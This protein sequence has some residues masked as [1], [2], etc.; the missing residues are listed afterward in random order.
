[1]ASLLRTLSGFVRE[2]RLDWAKSN[3]SRLKFEPSAPQRLFQ[4]ASASPAKWVGWTF[5]LFLL[6]TCLSALAP[7]P[8]PGL[9]DF[10][11]SDDKYT[12]VTAFL[13]LWAVQGA[14]VAVVYPI[15]V[16]FVTVLIQR[17]AASKASL[18]A[19]F[20]SSSAKLTGISSLALVLIMGVQFTTIDT[21]KPLLGFA[22]V[23]ADGVWFVA[24][25]LLSIHFL[26]A[27]FKFASPE[28]RIRA[29]NHYI[30]TR[31]WPEEW[32]YHISRL[33]AM[34]PIRRKLLNIPSGMEDLE[35]PNPAFSA[36]PGQLGTHAALKL[37]FRGA[38]KI[39]DVRYRVLEVAFNRWAKHAVHRTPQNTPG[40]KA[41][42]SRK[43]PIL[44]MGALVFNEFSHQDAL[45]KTNTPVSSSMLVRA[46]L[47]GSLKLSSAHKPRVTVLDALDESRLDAASAIGQDSVAD[48]ERRLEEFIEF[49]DQLIE[50]SNYVKDGKS[51]NWSLLQSSDEL[52][53]GRTLGRLW[54][55]S[56]LD[57]HSVALS[58]IERRPDFA[59]RTVRVPS[60]FF[61]RQRDYL[62]D[63]LK[64]RYLSL[65]FWHVRQLLDWGA[66]RLA[67]VADGSG[68]RLLGEPLRRRYERLIK[69][70][71][72]AW[73]SLKNWRLG[74]DLSEDLDWQQ[75]QSAAQLLEAHLRQ[76]AAFV[77]VCLRA[78]DRAGTYWFG[79]SFL[80]WR[81][82][83]ERYGAREGVAFLDKFKV[84]Y[85]DLS[86]NIGDFRRKFPLDAYEKESGATLRAAWQLAL[87]NFWKDVGLLLVASIATN[88]GA[89]DSHMKLSA[90]F[91]QSALLG[92]DSDGASARSERLFSGTDQ[93]IAA[94]IRV[95]ALG[96]E[97]PE[98]YSERLEGI[99]ESFSLS[100]VSEGI[101]GRIYSSVGT[102]LDRLDDGYLF[103]LAGLAS[104]GW[105][106]SGRFDDA[107][108]GWVEKDQIRQTLAYR[109]RRLRDRAAATIELQWMKPI[110]SESFQRS[111]DDF[112]KSLAS[113]VTALDDFIH[114]IERAREEDVRNLEPHP[115]E[116][117]RLEAYSS[118]ALQA[119]FREAPLCFFEAVSVEEQAFG[120][121][122]T[123]SVRIAGW[124]KGSLT[125]PRLA[126]P[127]SNEDDYI[128]D[129]VRQVASSLVIRAIVDASG[130]RLVGSATREEFISEVVQFGRDA[131]AVG[132]RPVLLVASRA[133]PPWLIDLA[134]G[135]SEDEKA[136]VFKRVGSA[137]NAPSYSG[138]IGETEV[139]VAPVPQ[140]EA[141]LCVA[142]MFHTL[143]VSARVLASA[144]AE[145]DAHRCTLGLSWGQLSELRQRQVVRLQY[146]RARSKRKRNGS[147]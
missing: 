68:G 31:A 3:P 60:R 136:P 8:Y 40:E 2:Q 86:L 29:R 109:F 61:I 107:I 71:I 67:T 43:G 12:P 105:K 77:T 47:R 79:D 4:A 144:S 9:F 138:H 16:A 66:E 131:V 26:T 111:S 127:V 13:G 133:D 73:E 110:W 81:S 118:Q 46:L 96:S 124:D 32:E 59:A 85:D 72:S 44:E 51:D 93:V 78:E 54:E 95:F 6:A 146:G 112:E 37:N 117:A 10:G 100:A 65:Q 24:N 57:L 53:G 42:F 130:A 18:E 7:P 137:Q 74:L 116:L 23:V 99:A 45:F 15:V 70:A 115:E 143:H 82:Q 36:M 134:R 17:Q 126:E 140:G 50:S 104:E 147:N 33:V 120:E 58:A 5:A 64:L 35:S 132:E 125:R 122:Q 121:N 103:T 119:P 113:V 14:M 27:T 62:C 123:G 90:A 39:V 38:K 1:M 19:Y 84:I 83:I 94:L 75:L 41:S 28:G 49:F 114:R 101:A 11:P 52:W 97:G 129:V 139:H 142:S 63:E 48:F 34:E 135:A 98:G 69:E 106:A 30:L 108:R 21:V 76:S 145:A 92:N 141:I 91:I 56:F 102:A 55:K 25:T 128:S 87:S 89:S 20:V 22:W 88:A 80:K